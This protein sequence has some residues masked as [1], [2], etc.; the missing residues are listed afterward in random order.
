MQVYYKIDRSTCLTLVTNLIFIVAVFS[1]TAAVSV[2]LC[3]LDW[4][5]TNYQSLILV[6]VFLACLLVYWLVLRVAFG[7]AKAL[8]AQ[9]ELRRYHRVRPTEEA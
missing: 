4:I 6:A 1:A 7:Y 2:Y 8:Y 9:W 5:E 3:Q